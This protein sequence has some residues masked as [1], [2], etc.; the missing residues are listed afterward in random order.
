MGWRKVQADDGSLFRWRIGTY[1]GCACDQNDLVFVVFLETPDWSPWH[2]IFAGPAEIDIALVT[3]M[4]Q[5]VSNVAFYREVR[6]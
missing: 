5:M 2:G 3:P 1:V 6:G 4:L